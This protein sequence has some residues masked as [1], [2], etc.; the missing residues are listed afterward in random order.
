MSAAE[1]HGRRGCAVCLAAD[2]LLLLSTGR[3]AMARTVLASQKATDTGLAA[4]C[5][6]PR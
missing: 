2:A 5:Q 3:A 4:A 1:P 6:P